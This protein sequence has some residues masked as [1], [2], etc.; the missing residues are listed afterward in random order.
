MI[1]LNFKFISTVEKSLES[2][3][4]NGVS[5]CTDKFPQVSQELVHNLVNRRMVRSV[6]T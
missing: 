5:S 6:S 4:V 1:E 3:I 2:L